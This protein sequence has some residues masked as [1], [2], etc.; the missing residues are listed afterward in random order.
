MALEK[1]RDILAEADKQHSSVIAFDAMDYATISAAIFGAEAM[2]RPVIVMLYPSMDRYMP[3]EAFVSMVKSFAA[4]VQVP[5]GLH[6]DHCSDFSY[7]LNAIRLGFSSVMADGSTLPFEENVQFTSSVVKAAK[8][9]GV[10]VEGELG[11]VGR[12]GKVEDYLATDQYT[13][14]EDAAMFAK[15]TGVSSLAIAIGSAHGFY[16]STPKLSIERLEEINQ[17]TDVPLVLHGGSGIPH[18]QLEIAFQKGINKFNVGTEFLHLN[19]TAAAEYFRDNPSP[20]DSLAQVA[21]VQRKLQ[22][23]I[24]DKILLTTYEL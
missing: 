19:Q 7:I 23:Y 12:A 22:D 1:V 2:H 14:P 11:H 20:K 4:K 3:L 13:R 18:D 10:D 5:V 24:E 17:A 15:R 8:V 6:L 16:K 9:F 21:Y